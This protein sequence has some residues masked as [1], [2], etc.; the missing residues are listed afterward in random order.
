MVVSR[1]DGF[2]DC[3]GKEDTMTEY[4]KNKIAS[5]DGADTVEVIIGIVVFVIFGLTV[6]GMVTSAAGNKAAAISNCLGKSGSIIKQ[7]GSGS[8]FDT[9]KQCKETNHS[10]TYNG[11]SN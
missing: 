11:Q 4:L 9:T 6:F 8:D 7:T 10:Y 1:H 3:I 2:S 5:E